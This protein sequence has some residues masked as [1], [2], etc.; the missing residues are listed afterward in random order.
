MKKAVIIVIAVLILLTGCANSSGIPQTQSVLKEEKPEVSEL[1]EDVA[2]NAKEEEPVSNNTVSGESY[3]ETEKKEDISENSVEEV[4][5]ASISED[6]ISENSVSEDS[7]T[8]EKPNKIKKKNTKKAAKTEVSRV[9]IEDCGSDTGY[10]DIT[11][12]DGSHDYIDVP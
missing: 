12:S 6:I 3:L 7:Q 8:V 4:K 10:W 9:F 11:Y 1:T 5:S 2:E